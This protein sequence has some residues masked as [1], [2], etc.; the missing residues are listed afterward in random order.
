MDAMAWPKIESLANA[1]FSELSA[2]YPL[3]S[4]ACN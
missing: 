3:E 1:C 4:L 2:R